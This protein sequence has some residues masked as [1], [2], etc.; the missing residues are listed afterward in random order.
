MINFCFAV[1]LQRS[2]MRVRTVSARSGRTSSK[3]SL[4]SFEIIGFSWL[5]GGA[6]SGEHWYDWLFL[7]SK[8]TARL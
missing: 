2:S 7:K 3:I 4:N 1:E 6:W 8:F 5:E